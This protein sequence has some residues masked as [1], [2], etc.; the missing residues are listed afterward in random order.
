M[1]FIQLCPCCPAFTYHVNTIILLILLFNSVS[2]TLA[3]CVPFS[4][5]SDR[6][7]SA[8]SFSACLLREERGYFRRVCCIGGASQWHHHAWNRN[9]TTSFGDAYPFV[10]YIQRPL[11]ARGNFSVFSA[12]R[13]ALPAQGKEIWFAATD[14]GV[15]S[16]YPIVWIWLKRLS[17][18]ATSH[19]AIRRSKVVLWGV[20]YCKSIY[21]SLC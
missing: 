19:D 14:A 12:W 9:R 4:F 6:E 11:E 18:T 10:V 3:L 20:E 21:V 1:C 13:F 17:K 7:W 2:F 8:A 16:K 5:R 15:I